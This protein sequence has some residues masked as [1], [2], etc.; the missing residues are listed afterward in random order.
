MPAEIPD[1][2]VLVARA[3]LNSSLWTMPNNCRLLAI[4]GICIACWRPRKWWDGKKEVI[5]QR[6]QFVRSWQGLSTSAQLTIKE[7]RRASEHLEKVDFW[8]R[9]RAGRYSI[10]TIHKYEHYQD[11][12]KYSDSVV[13]EEGKEVGRPRADG[14]Q[15]GGNIQEGNKEI[16]KDTPPAADAAGL[17]VENPLKKRRPEP[18]E[19][20]EFV[21]W[22]TEYPACANKH[23]RDA[24]RKL[25]LILAPS[26][27]LAGLLVE[28]LREHKR[29]REWQS[30]DGRFIPK[31][32]NWLRSKSWEGSAEVLASRALAKAEERRREKEERTARLA[33]RERLDKEKAELAANPERAKAVQTKIDD[34][35]AKFNAGRAKFEAD[36]EKKAPAVAAPK[37]YG[38]I[39]TSEAK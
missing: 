35:V 31:P 17:N 37:A 5:L 28:V 4:T 30:E 25:W 18:W 34:A 3:I 39:K 21:R 11:M 32:V 20:P 26:P 8:A 10:F 15:R 38:E 36:R 29:S 9:K 16:S 14:G 27:D 6:G 1:G 2:A 12:G 13:R 22:W 7:I 33:E 23:D 19:P 24:A